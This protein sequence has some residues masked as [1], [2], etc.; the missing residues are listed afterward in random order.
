MKITVKSIDSG[1]A[2]LDVTGEV[3]SSGFAA[4]KNGG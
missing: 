1:S 4:G 3:R 2:E